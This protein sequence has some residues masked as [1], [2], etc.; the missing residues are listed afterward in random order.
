[1]VPVT[2]NEAETNSF[3]VKSS[4]SVEW[5]IKDATFE[6]EV[7]YKTKTTKVESLDNLV[8]ILTN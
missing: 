7:N 8:I 1:M 6:F 4:K 5:K 3:R 2:P